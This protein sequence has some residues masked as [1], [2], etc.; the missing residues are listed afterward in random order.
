M[1][2]VFSVQLENVEYFNC[3]GSRIANDA[4]CTCEFKSRISMAEA[5]F[6]KKTFHWQIGHEFKKE[7]SKMLHLEHSFVWC[8]N[9][10]TLESRSIIPGKFLIVVLEKDG[11]DQL[12]KSY[13]N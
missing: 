2:S 1:K 6:N 10:D 11:E 5:D 7:T 9:L 8:R 4:I 13:E 3:L 12:D